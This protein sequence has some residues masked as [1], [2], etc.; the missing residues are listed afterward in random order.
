M[1]VFRVREKTAFRQGGIRVDHRIIRLN[2]AVI[3]SSDSIVLIANLMGHFP[4]ANPYGDVFYGWAHRRDGLAIFQSEGLA[5]AF[6]FWPL[7]DLR[8][9]RKTADESGI[10]AEGRK[11]VDHVLAKSLNERAHQHQHTNA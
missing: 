11:I 4:V 8:P 3:N 7:A 6:L 2:A 5:F 10:C 1:F 9:L